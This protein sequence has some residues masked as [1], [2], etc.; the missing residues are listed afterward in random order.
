MLQVANRLLGKPAEFLGV[1]SLPNCAIFVFDRC[2]TAALLSVHTC[3]PA[4]LRFV[5]AVDSTS[6][7]SFEH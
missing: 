2:S 6:V 4:P 1:R 7:E 3:R 5:F